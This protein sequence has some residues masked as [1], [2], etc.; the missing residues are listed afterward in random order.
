MLTMSTSL[1]TNSNFDFIGQ[2][3]NFGQDHGLMNFGNAQGPYLPQNQINQ[4]QQ[5]PQYFYQSEVSNECY[6]DIFYHLY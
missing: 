2:N 3:T 4:Q 1:L 6:Q 5:Q